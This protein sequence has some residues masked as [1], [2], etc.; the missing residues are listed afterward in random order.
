MTANALPG[1]TTRLRRSRDR[2]FEDF[3]W[4][5]NWM[6][7][8]FS[9]Y[10]N[11]DWMNFGPLRVMV[12]NHI[13]PHSGFPSHPHRDVEVLTYVVAGT[14][15]HNDSFGHKAEVKAGEMQL[16]S[17]GSSGMVHSEYNHHEEIEHNYQMWLIPDRVPTSFGYHQLHFA[18]QERQGCLKLYVSPDGRQGSMPIN[19]DALIYAGLFES[20][21][22]VVYP[23]TLSRG[24]WLQVVNGAVRVANH[25]LYEGDGIGITQVE[26]I[27]LIF[28]D[29][30]EILFFDLNMNINTSRLG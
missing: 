29:Q 25:D 14:L 23:L 27:E 6:T 26:H 19:T 3:G 20:G 7:F 21:D 22:R 10:Y 11:P 5:D 28:T 17:A 13:Q 4:T 2:G 30:S 18:D 8:S 1:P 12:E 24:A 9:G 15:T 16:I